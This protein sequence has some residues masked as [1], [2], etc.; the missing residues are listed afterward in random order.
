MTKISLFKS[1]LKGSC[2]QCRNGQ[3]FSSKNPFVL[4]KMTK[5]KPHCTNCN[6]K[7][8]SEPSFFTGAMYIGY[9]F[10]VGLVL[11][12]FLAFQLTTERPSTSSMIF[13]TVSIA[14]ILA[15]INIRLSRSIWMHLFHKYKP[16]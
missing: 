7:V 2:P 5:M 11:S 4:K 13:T 16:E 14:F 6:F 1:I 9:G 10:S 8:E 12:V 15:P 3:V